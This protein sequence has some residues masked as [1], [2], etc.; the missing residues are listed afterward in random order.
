MAGPPGV[1]RQDVQRLSSPRKMPRGRRLTCEAGPQTV[2][3]V[4]S[5]GKEMTMEAAHA[6]SRA[7]TAADWAGRIRAELTGNILPFWLRHVLDR[8]HGGFF[9]EVGSDLTVR[10][11][12]PRACVENTRILWTYAAAAREIV[13]ELMARL[14]PVERMLVTL[15]HLEGRSGKEVA[16]MM[17]WTHLRVRVQGYRVRQKLKKHFRQLLRD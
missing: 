4:K 11:D 14:L 9:G 3:A 15:L 16:Q 6:V 5:S 12:A 13:D 7:V 1:G 8:A 2:S 10:A 17:G